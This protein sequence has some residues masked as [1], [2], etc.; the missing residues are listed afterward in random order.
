M[1]EA[2]RRTLRVFISSPSDVRPERL[3]AER[4]VR[5]LHQEFASHIDLRAVMWEREPLLA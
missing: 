5:H 1:S 2:E 4:M 3:I